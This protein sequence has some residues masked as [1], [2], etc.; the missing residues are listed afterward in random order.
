MPA[1]RLR[2]MT[3]A[4]LKLVLTWRNHPDVYQ[5]MYTRNKISFEEHLRWFGGASVDPTRHLLILE[6]D[7]MPRGYV[8]FRCHV[9]RAAVWGFY[10]APDATKGTGRLL[11]EVA[12]SYAF[13]V[14][15]LE[16]IWGE[17]LPDNLA[18][19]KFHQRHGF[20]LESILTANITGD[21]KVGNVHRYLLTKDNWLKRQGTMK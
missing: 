2:P 21:H 15:G 1:V 5:H 6:V 3:D 9:T 12:T 7:A 11:G 17:V 8:N 10:L 18:S 13:G 20:V 19:Q 16:T 4:D 14:L